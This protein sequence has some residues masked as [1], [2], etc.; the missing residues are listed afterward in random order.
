MEDPKT[1]E[2]APAVPEKEPIQSVEKDT[3]V[4]DKKPEDLPTDKKDNVA[5]EAKP[6]LAKPDSDS[7]ITPDVNDEMAP[8][9]GPGKIR[10]DD[11]R[12]KPSYSEAAGGGSEKKSKL[13]KPRPETSSSSSGK[14]LAI[15]FDGDRIMDLDLEASDASML[16]LSTMEMFDAVAYQKPPP[17]R[18]SSLPPTVEE[19]EPAGDARSSPQKPPRSRSQD[20]YDKNS[21]TRRK[22]KEVDTR[23][24]EDN[25]RLRRLVQEL[26]KKNQNL[27]LEKQ[28]AE[29]K[30]ER[31]HERIAEMKHHLNSDMS[32][33]ELNTEALGNER[34]KLRDE[35]RALREQLSDAQSHIFSLQPYRKDL[36]PEEVGRV[37]HQLTSTPPRNRTDLLNRSLMHL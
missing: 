15:D 27:T 30:S 2:L 14:E 9:N 19:D 31:A 3:E 34:D 20:N 25:L 36:T 11:M 10:L 8:E 12:S 18:K 13:T 33:I 5:A 28:I 21:Y 37:S 17:A 1:Q 4:G 23:D 35:N 7:S 24:A 6:E 22:E 16:G 26:M 32:E 29:E